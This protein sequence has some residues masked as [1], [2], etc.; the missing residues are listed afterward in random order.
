MADAI[1]VEAQEGEEL[2]PVRYD[3]AQSLVLARTEARG[4]FRRWEA[5]E[6][7]DWA[8]AQYVHA[9]DN[10]LIFEIN[11]VIRKL[12]EVQGVERRWAHD[13]PKLNIKATYSEEDGTV[14]ITVN[15][16]VV[17]SNRQP[18][19]ELLVAGDWLFVMLDKYRHVLAGERWQADINRQRARAKAHDSLNADV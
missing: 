9:H 13:S 7:Y 12:G 15:G 8:R 17:L 16:G 14:E 19:A 18:G 5:T 2:A 6:M 1:T 4:L 10:N 11:E 3:V